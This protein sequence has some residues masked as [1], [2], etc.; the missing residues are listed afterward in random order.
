MPMSL[1]MHFCTHTAR[2]LVDGAEVEVPAPRHTAEAPGSTVRGSLTDSMSPRHKG[3]PD[4]TVEVPNSY[5]SGKV[6]TPLTPCLFDSPKGPSTSIINS[7]L[8]YRSGETLTPR[9]LPGTQRP[10]LSS[11]PVTAPIGPPTPSYVSLRRSGN[12][13]GCKRVGI[14]P[15]CL[16]LFSGGSRWL[17]RLPPGP[18]SVIESPGTVHR[19]R[20]L[21]T[22]TLGPVLSDTSRLSVRPRPLGNLS[23]DVHG[24][25]DGSHEPREVFDPSILTLE[26]PSETF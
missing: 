19:T 17:S 25:T 20:R 5:R 18:L 8:R 15:R 21:D 26:C 13:D 12:V 22:S 4:G 2:A 16:R 6:S 14:L 11:A 3:L 7:G 1:G 23:H 10:P 9:V 24:V